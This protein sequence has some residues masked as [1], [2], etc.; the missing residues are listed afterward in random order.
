MAAP[1]S[2]SRAFFLELVLDIVIFVLCAAVA[3]QVFVQ[4]R[5]TSDESAALTHLSLEAQQLAETFKASGDIAEP[6]LYFDESFLRCDASVARYRLVCAI[7][8]SQSPLSTAEI[9]VFTDNLA[10][11]SETKLFSLTASHY[12]GRGGGG[13]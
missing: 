7:D 10:E 11:H 8:S 3:L 2:R 1:T 12:A 13:N 4:A 6:T 5:V 9:T